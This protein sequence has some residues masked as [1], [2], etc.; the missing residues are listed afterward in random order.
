M[1]SKVLSTQCS[2]ERHTVEN[3]AADMKITEH[4]WGADKLFFDPVYVHDNAPNVTK[5]PKMMEM[6]RLGIGCLVHT[7]NPAASSATSI[8]QVSE[9]LIMGRKIV[10]I[11]KRSILATN[12]SKKKQELLLP[13]KQHKLIP[14]CPTRWNSSYDMLQRLSE[15]SQVRAIVY[16]ETYWK[17][18]VYLLKYNLGY[19]KARKK[20]LTGVLKHKKLR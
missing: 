5:A 6:P 9:I 14:D 10:A 3:L 17:S 7:I 11:F 1:K 20:N 8:Q 19:L 13:N 15:Q 12:V 4:K 16:L 18:F 2:E